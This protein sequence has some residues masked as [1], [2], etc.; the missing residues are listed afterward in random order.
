MAGV[1]H[2]HRHRLWVRLSQKGLWDQKF[3]PSQGPG[4]HV[5]RR[6]RIDR[7]AAFYFALIFLPSPKI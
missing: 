1:E 4:I 6:A 7:R 5:M 3:N 2:L